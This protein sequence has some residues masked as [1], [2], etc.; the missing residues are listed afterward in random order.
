MKT[1]YFS[2]IWIVCILLCL[3]LL[4]SCKK[5]SD[6]AQTQT[7]HV[8]GIIPLPLNVDL[9]E[10]NLSIDKNI[11]L[12]TNPQFQSAVEVIENALNQALDQAVIKSD[13]PS[14][15]T[16]IQ[17]S[18][19]NTLDTDAYQITVS[20]KGIAIKAKTATGAFY[21]AQS[22][23]QMIWNS[24]SGLKTETFQ[25]RCMAINDKPFYAWRGFHLDVSR[26]FF[27]KEY[28]FKIIDWLA[29][30][31]LNKLQL[32][33][34][35]DQGW[36]IQIDQ[37]PLLTEIG[38]WRA[39]N[40]MDSTCMDLAKTDINYTI[41]KRFIK[42]ENGKTLYGG[43]YTKQDIRDIVT[44]ATTHY[45]DVIPE[46][47]MPGHMSAAI[48][49]YPELSCVDSAG[50]GTEFSFP[51]C[52]CNEQ[53]MD[54]SFK[55]WDEIIYLFPSKVVHIGCDEVEK[56]T[57]AASSECQAFMVQNNMSSLNEIQNYFV[58]KLQAHLQA[59]GKT[60]V[61]WDD[62]IDGSVDNKITM[63]YWRDWVKDSPERCAANGNALVLTPATPF[64]L[65]SVNTDEALANLYN[66]NP[67]DKYQSAVLAKVQGFQSCLWTEI[68]PSEPMFEKYVF[69]RLQALA[70]IG[71]TPG[72]NWYS[73]Q[74]RMKPHFEYMN[75]TKINYRRPG[76]AK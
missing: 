32:H 12:V 44:Y 61:A 70:E 21:A 23:R 45:V 20:E 43:F 36:R 30:Y 22:L 38:A 42:A 11:V 35:D 39:F 73:F 52:P 49:A 17:F 33:L 75:L 1:N 67:A 65:A 16:N 76:W 60:V 69:P 27:T 56:G 5:T 19:E 37:Y 71:W 31:K 63:M 62:V 25:L 8:H 7:S 40:E 29:Y 57:W 53:V 46:I 59:K 9:F 58:E 14:G 26:H 24:T 72:R 55:V 15:K 13:L 50:W 51:I 3:P 41:D 10:G 28:I 18:I 2:N 48:R 47:D 54:F 64:Y 68:V 74:V 6:S 34:T 4:P 66:Y